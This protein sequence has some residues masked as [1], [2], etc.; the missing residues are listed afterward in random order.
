VSLLESLPSAEHG[1]LAARRVRLRVRQNRRHRP[2]WLLVPLDFA[3]RDGGQY[4][5]FDQEV[6]PDQAGDHPEQGARLMD[7]TRGHPGGGPV[8]EL[9]CG[10]TGSPTLRPLPNPRA[11]CGQIEHRWRR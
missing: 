1:V 8:I 11:D 3:R 7:R 9:E 2:G 4:F 5:Y 10:I 6:W